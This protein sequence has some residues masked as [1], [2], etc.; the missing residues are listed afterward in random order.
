MFLEKIKLKHYCRFCAVVLLLFIHTGI[1]MN[2]IRGCYRESKLCYFR[3]S[4]KITRKS[5]V[6]KKERMRMPSPRRIR[7]RPWERSR[8]S[9]R[10]TETERHMV[11]SSAVGQQSAGKTRWRMRHKLFVFLRGLCLLSRLCAEFKLW[12]RLSRVEFSTVSCWPPP[13]GHFRY[14]QYSVLLLFA[15]R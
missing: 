6:R 15:A 10:W 2:Q 14:V 5:S 4:S 3:P 13:Q 11:V 1:C 8:S 9:Q 12:I 7:V